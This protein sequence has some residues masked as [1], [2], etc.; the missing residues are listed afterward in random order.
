MTN[1]KNEFL[2]YIPVKNINYEE[3]NG[4]II[5]LVPKIAKKYEK[6]FFK[7]WLEKPNK[8]DLDEIGSFI[9]KNIDGQTSVT[10]IIN[11]C[12]SELKEKIEPALDRIK[13]FLEQMNRNGFIK[14]YKKISD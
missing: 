8:I 5:L 10:E 11:L 9:W 1:E 3:E 7:K 6:L 13:L 14:L 2:N 4:I 12:Q